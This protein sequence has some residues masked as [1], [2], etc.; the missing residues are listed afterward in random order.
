MLKIQKRTAQVLL[1][2]SSRWREVA[3]VGGGEV[4]EGDIYDSHSN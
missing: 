4:A 3:E 1:S 2:W